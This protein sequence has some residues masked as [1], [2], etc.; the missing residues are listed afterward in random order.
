MPVPLSRP[1]FMI[2]NQARSESNSLGHDWLGCEH[3]LLGLLH[4]DDPAARE[5]TAEGIA[6]EDAR[7]EVVRI[8]G[9]RNEPN[10]TIAPLTRDAERVIEAA[11]RE[12]SLDDSAQVQPMHLLHALLAEP[13]GTHLAVLKRLY[14]RAR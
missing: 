8:V 2:F 13:D 9:V 4:Q 7:A 14:E 12:A 5:L 10:T 6:L 1:M 3:L 11:Q